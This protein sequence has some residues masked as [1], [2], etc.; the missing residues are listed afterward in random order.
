MNLTIPGPKGLPVSGNLLA[1]RRDPLGFLQEA[2]SEHGDIVH[3]RFGP[4]RHIYLLTNPEHI[5]E[6][7]VVK[8]EHFRKAKGLQVAKVVVGEGILTS[9]GKKHLRQRRLMQPAFHRE[10]IAAYGQTMVDLTLAMIEQWRDGE[11]I[12]VHDEMM[13]VT[14]AIITKTMFGKGLKEGVDKIGQA[15]EVGLHYVSTKASSFIDIPLSVPTRS[16]LKFREAAET[17]DK[18]I[19]A[20]ID[21]RRRTGNTE[22]TDLLGMLLAA[23]DEDDGTGMTDK[24]VRDEV[25]TIFLAGHETTANTMSWIWYLLATHPEAEKKLQSELDEVL[26]GRTPTVEDIPRLAYVNQIISEAMRLYP[27]AWAI[28][29]E[30]VDEVDIGGQTFHPGETLMMSQ[31]VM[32]RNPKYYD[33]PDQFLPERFAGDLL[34]RIP[35]F[36]YFPFGGGPRICIGNNFA[37]MEAALLLAAIAQRCRLPLANPERPVEPEPLVTLRPKN[38]LPVRVEKRS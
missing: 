14:L 20:I 38:G 36:A 7:L 5:K 19:Y 26:G 15:I 6:V 28:S 4:T 8:H 22:R 29:R 17:L 27:A 3:F 2:A 33:N 30:V 10:R 9:E 23:R 21:E 1:F 18:A 31:Y 16:N 32:H 12:D 34:K 11:E 37:R 13:K 35:S 25:M 24:Q